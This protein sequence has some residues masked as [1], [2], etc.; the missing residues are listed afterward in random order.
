[1]TP[2]PLS[3]TIIAWFLIVTS[4][5]GAFGVW[6]SFNDP[7]AEQILAKSPLPRS[8]HI[9]VSAGSII[10][11]LVFGVALL[12]RQNWARYGYVGVGVAGIVFGYFTSP[13]VAVILLSVVFLVVVGFF[14]FRGPA[15]D[16]FRG[17]SA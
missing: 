9:A 7:L 3:V 17:A 14:L 12:K 1:M 5:F 6:S 10:L 11:N 2:R 13:F 15:N 16:W 8:V 4:I